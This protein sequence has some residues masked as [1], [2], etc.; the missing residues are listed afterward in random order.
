M[1]IWHKLEILRAINIVAQKVY[2]NW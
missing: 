1:L 2:F